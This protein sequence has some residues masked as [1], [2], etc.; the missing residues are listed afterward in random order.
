M[1]PD[2]SKCLNESCPLKERCYRFKCA[3]SEY[4]TYSDFQPNEDGSC[5]WFMEEEE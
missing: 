3:G 4:Q 1:M 5:D 2:I